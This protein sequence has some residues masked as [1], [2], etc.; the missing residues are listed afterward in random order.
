M[1]SLSLIVVVGLALTSLEENVAP[2]TS[3][4]LTGVVKDNHGV[5]LNGVMVR[6]SDDASGLADN[7]F[8]DAEGK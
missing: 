3:S 6:V 2:L 1:K 7:V 8:T 5:P 4:L